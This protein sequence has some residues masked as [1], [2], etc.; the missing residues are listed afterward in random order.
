MAPITG[1][2]FG[3]VADLHGMQRVYA[4]MQ[5]TVIGPGLRELGFK[6][7]KGRFV[8]GDGQYEATIDFQKSVNSTRDLVLFT[9]NLGVIHKEGS[10]LYWQAQRSGFFRQWGAP[11]EIRVRTDGVFWRSRLYELDHPRIPDWYGIDGSTDI[12]LL[13]GQV[14]EDVRSTALPVMFANMDRDLELPGYVVETL[15][16]VRLFPAPS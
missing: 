16:G 4:E 5:R 11:S 13:G 8:L 12:S 14:V 15:G 3:V 1:P 6:G 10:A 7:S 9:L 2:T